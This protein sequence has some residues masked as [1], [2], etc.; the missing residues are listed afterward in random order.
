MN[1]DTR[2]YWYAFLSRFFADV[3]SARLLEE[4][5]ANSEILGLIG[6]EANHYLLNTDNE[7]L[8]EELNID[9]TTVFITNAPP[10]ESAVLDTKNQIASG[11]ENPVM[12]FYLRY[13]YEINLNNT[14]L[15]TPDHLAIELGFMQ[16]LVLHEPKDTQKQF[17]SEHLL[18]WVVPY[19]LGVKEL[20]VTPFYR[21]L[22]DFTIEFLISDFETLNSEP[23]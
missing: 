6:E 2:A 7:Q 3:P 1:I 8:L 17:L 12:G 22:V 14:V 21:Q 11:L 20:L 13:G 16:N 18:V 10:L 15:L 9:Y 19:M 4:L 5:R 23:A